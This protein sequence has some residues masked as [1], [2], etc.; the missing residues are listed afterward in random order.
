LSFQQ[1]KN[2]ENPSR[3]IDNVIAV[4]LVYV[5]LFGTHCIM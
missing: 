5:L 2:F 3:I 4:S 1:L